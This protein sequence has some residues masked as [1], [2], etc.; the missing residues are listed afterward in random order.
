[1]TGRKYIRKFMDTKTNLS[2]EIS[3]VVVGDYE[4]C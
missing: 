1:M 4:F 3:S 2:C